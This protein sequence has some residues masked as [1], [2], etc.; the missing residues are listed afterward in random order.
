MVVGR[1]GRRAGDR[2]VRVRKERVTLENDQQRRALD[3][4]TF[5]KINFSQGKEKLFLKLILDDIIF[6]F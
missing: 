2:I 1:V 6:N 3:Q 4:R 5:I